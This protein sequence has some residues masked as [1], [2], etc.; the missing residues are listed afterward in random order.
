LKT[1]KRYDISHLVEAQFEPGSHERV[2][3]NLLGI[4]RKR[5]MDRFEAREHLRTMEQLIRVYDKNHRFNAADIC[6]I[7]RIWLGNIYAWGVIIAK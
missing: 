6:R 2:L 1:S 4:K 3:K 5:E 7:H